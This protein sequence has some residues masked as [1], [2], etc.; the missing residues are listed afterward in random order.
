MLARLWPGLSPT[1]PARN[2]ST[3][4]PLISMSVE[5]GTMESAASSDLRFHKRA[6]A[7]A[8]VSKAGVAVGINGGLQHDRGQHGIG[9][10]GELLERLAENGMQ[11]F[12]LV[13]LVRPSV[14]RNK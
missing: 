5:M 13:R 4:S 9:N 8:V 3:S 12:D 10:A 11:A 1:T 6:S 2:F 14:D 7:L